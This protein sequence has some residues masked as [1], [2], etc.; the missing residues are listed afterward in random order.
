MLGTPDAVAAMTRAGLAAF[1]RDRYPVSAMTL[2]I[3]GDVEL[4]T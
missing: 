4:D 2:A 3:V 1:Y